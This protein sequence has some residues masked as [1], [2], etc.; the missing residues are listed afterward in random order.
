MLESACKN[1]LLMKVILHHDNTRPHSAAAT[2]EYLN[3]ANVELMDHP[4]YS[5]NLVSN[6]FFLFRKRKI[7]CV[8]CSLMRQEKPFKNWK[9]SY[10]FYI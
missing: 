7:K 6:H 1:R 5:S 10:K 4:P 8:E 9:I 3:T 2:I